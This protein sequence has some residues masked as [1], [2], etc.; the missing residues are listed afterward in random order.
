M[1]VQ[2]AECLHNAAMMMLAEAEPSEVYSMSA[3]ER[4]EHYAF[5]SGVVAQK[6]LSWKRFL[7][8]TSEHRQDA[9]SAYNKE[10]QSIISMG[11]MRF[12]RWEALVRVSCKRVPW[13]M[14]QRA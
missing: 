9:I 1:S 2:E 14:I 13:S 3:A 6:G 7:E 12:E 8:P 11:V 5:V 4:A 10:L